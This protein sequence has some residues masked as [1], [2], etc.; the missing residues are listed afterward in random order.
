MLAM[1]TSRPS[2]VLRVDRE[3][4]A[5]ALEQD[6]SHASSRICEC[7]EVE[8]VKSSDLFLPFTVPFCL[9]HR[10]SSI[11]LGDLTLL[12]ASTIGFADVST[13]LRGSDINTC[14]IGSTL[15][16]LSRKRLKVVAVGCIT[17]LLDIGVVDF[18]AELVELTLDVA[19]DLAL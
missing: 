15:M 14:L 4:S 10:R 18:Q 9:L 5:A 11:D 19:K 1:S 13:Q 2:V 7:F 3:A 12:L 6:V 17:Q 8:K 16:R